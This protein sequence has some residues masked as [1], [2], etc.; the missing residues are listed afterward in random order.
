MIEEDFLR[1]EF[2]CGWRVIE[3]PD[4]YT[5]INLKGEIMPHRFWKVSDFDEKTG[6]AQVQFLKIGKGCV[7]Y[8][9][10]VLLMPFDGELVD[11]LT[12]DKSVYKIH[13]PHK[14]ITYR[15]YNSKTQ[16]LEDEFSDW[17]IAK[18]FKDGSRLVGVAKNSYH[19]VDKN[20]KIGIFNYREWLDT[21]VGTLVTIS[22]LTW[23]F[24]QD[25]EANNFETYFLDHQD[26]NGMFFTGKK[27][28]AVLTKDGEFVLCDSKK[29]KP[30]PL[31]RASET[32]HKNPDVLLHSKNITVYKKKPS[33]K[34]YSVA[35]DVEGHIY[36]LEELGEDL[37]VS[38]AYKNNETKQV[39]LYGRHNGEE[40]TWWNLDENGNVDKLSDVCEYGYDK[41]GSIVSKG[42]TVIFKAR[43]IENQSAKSL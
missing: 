19:F 6:V 18:T 2:H 40:M 5:F 29:I 41:H 13:L 37:K 28:K 34:Y 36:S 35:L 39:Y 9:G 22:G 1:A 21:S 25:G 20:G 43:D 4:G 15:I 11:R 38:G 8:D 27:G 31:G 16:K 42:K 7:T 12:N 30:Q 10:R 33:Q 23:T 14:R 32:T 26:E 3:K 17:K 24:I